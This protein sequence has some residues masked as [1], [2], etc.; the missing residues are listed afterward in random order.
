MLSPSQRCKLHL[1]FIYVQ[2]FLTICLVDCGTHDEGMLFVKYLLV[3][4]FILSLFLIIFQHEEGICWSLRAVEMK[5]GAPY[6]AN[7]ARAH[8][9]LGVGY[10]M[11][12]MHSA[13]FYKEYTTRAIETIQK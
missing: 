1:F 10:H 9:L 12:A 8:L 7:S 6:G 13:K 3:N 4:S 5:D 11:K 2:F